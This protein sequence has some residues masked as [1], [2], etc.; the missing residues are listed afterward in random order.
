MGQIVNDIG[1]E[2]INNWSILYVK[3]KDLN[4][5]ILSEQLYGETKSISKIELNNLIENS[6]FNA[7]N[8]T[9]DIV[10]QYYEDSIY[11]IF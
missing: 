9:S 6:I 7:S 4:Y 5:L 8:N 2:F 3:I 1:L 11:Y 10:G